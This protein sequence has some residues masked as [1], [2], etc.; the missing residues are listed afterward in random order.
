MNAPTPKKLPQ[1]LSLHGDDRRD[2]Y[3]WM[4]EREDPEVIAHLQAENA[5]FDAKMAHLKDFREELF[6]EI[7]G[8]IKQ[9]DSSVPYTNRGYIYRTAYETGDQ[10]PPLLPQ[11]RRRR[12]GGTDVQRQ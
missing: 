9:D 1:T 2:D 4:K 6:E 3:Y 11:T 5:Y 8:R 7:K 10:Y 12:R